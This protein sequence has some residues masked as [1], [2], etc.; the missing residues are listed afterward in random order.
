[1]RAT[2]TGASG[3]VGAAV[4]RRLL[5]VGASV[6]V[7]VREDTRA[8]DRLD[9][10]LFPGDLFDTSSLARAFD[11]AEVVFHVAGRI[12]IAGDPTGEVHRTNVLGTRNVAAA[13]LVAGVRRIIHFSSI[14]AFRDPGPGRLLDENG[15]LADEARFPAYDRSKAA[16]Q[17]EVEATL[18]RGLEAVVLHPAACIGPHDFKPSRMGRVLLDLA[19]GRVPALVAGGFAWVDTRDVAS[20]AVTAAGSAPSGSHY[21]LVGTWRSVRDVAQ[22][23]AD[24]VGTRAPRFVCPL[25][26][27]RAAAP[28]AE[29]VARLRGTEPLF[30]AESLLALSG[31]RNVSATR[32]VADLGFSPRPL[33]ETIADTLEWFRA[34]GTS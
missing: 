9:V 17:N 34:A 22:I 11:G 21:L 29:A 25:P 18:G 13:C 10:E 32:A 6:R 1:M 27:A 4:V 19:A 7:L 23:V 16:G 30:T 15:A 33:D 24:H 26:L 2:V 20:A 12:S 28:F 31:H 3:H 5:E 14:H 8:V